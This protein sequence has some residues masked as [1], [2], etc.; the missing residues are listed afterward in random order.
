M[1]LLGARK[2]DFDAENPEIGAQ[3]NSLAAVF[4]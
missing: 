4:G 1:R 2:I 3:E